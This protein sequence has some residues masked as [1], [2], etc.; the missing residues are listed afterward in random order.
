MM[1]IFLE[2]FYGDV[3]RLIESFTLARRSLMRL[4]EK[5]LQSYSLQI[6]RVVSVKLFGLL[7]NASALPDLKTWQGLRLRLLFLQTLRS[8]SF[9]LLKQFL[10]TA[11]KIFARNGQSLKRNTSFKINQRSSLL[12]LIESLMAVEV[13]IAISIFSMKRLTSRTC[14]TFTRAWSFQ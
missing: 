11:R 6:A 13:I 14:L 3:T 10:K 8:L 2:T 7:L 4:T 1:E 9:Q 5:S 12:A